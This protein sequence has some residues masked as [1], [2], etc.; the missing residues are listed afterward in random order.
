MNFEHPDIR[1]HSKSKPKANKL[2]AQLAEVI[3]S[4]I[5]EAMLPVGH[6]IGSEAD[7]LAHYNT[8]RSTFR[9]AVRQLETHGLIRTRRGNNGGLIVADTPQQTVIKTLA[10]HLELIDVNLDE[11]FEALTPLETRAA[12]LAA[13]R[14]SGEDLERLRALA[15]Q[16]TKASPSVEGV[17]TQ[18]AIREL[19]AV[20]TQNPA[21]TLLIGAI[22]RAILELTASGFGASA[23]GIGYTK[24]AKRKNAIVEAISARDAAG[25][26][27]AMLT[28]L[29][30]RKK[31]MESS[32]VPQAR[33]IER[34]GASPEAQSG[35]GYGPKL[36]QRMAVRIARRIMQGEVSPG[37]PLGTEPQLMDELGISRTTLREAIRLLELHGL[38]VTR[39]GYGGGL[40][41]GSPDPSYTI[42]TTVDYIRHLNI[43]IAHLEEARELLAVAV[44]GLSAR[45]CNHSDHLRLTEILAAQFAAE[46]ES[47]PMAAR[48]V[49]VAIAET[50]GNPVLTLLTKTLLAANLSESPH[51]LSPTEIKTFNRNH[52]A[53]IAAIGAGDEKLSKLRARQHIVYVKRFLE[54]QRKSS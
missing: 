17:A 19:I 33:K 6:V 29:L 25:A 51:P 7:L 52:S 20:M 46:P 34:S 27:A 16:L 43:D 22:G 37:E 3:R 32:L 54:R 41:G 40:M 44:A 24:G 39:R 12:G 49:Q 8:S 31:R 14:A 30:Q 11:L 10:T 15:E 42:E 1:S 26:E 21:L 48:A 2:G 45:R 13:E 35:Y 18:L 28:D 5:L 53:L 50:S 36:A 47:F 9:E 38:V 4:E 23:F